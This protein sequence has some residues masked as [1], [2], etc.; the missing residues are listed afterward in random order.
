MFKINDNDDDDDEFWKEFP[1]ES[2]EVEPVS[3]AEKRRRSPVPVDCEQNKKLRTFT[4]DDEPM[5]DVIIPTSPEPS[6]SVSGSNKYPT[7]GA[8]PAN[9]SQSLQQANCSILGN[10]SKEKTPKCSTAKLQTDVTTEVNCKR[11]KRIF[12]GPAGILPK[13]VSSDQLEDVVLKLDTAAVNEKELQPVAVLTPSQTH[14]AFNESPWKKLMSDLGEEASDILKKFSIKE[15]HRRAGKKLL[16]QGKV[17]LLFS[18]LDAI[19]FS[20]LDASVHLRDKTGTIQG[21]VH[22]NLVK[23][24]RDYLQPGTVMVLKNVGVISPTPRTHYLNITTNNLVSICSVLTSGEV[25]IHWQENNTS[26]SK[27]VAN[28]R[29]VQNTKAPQTSGSPLP[30]GSVINSPKLPSSL[31]PLNGSPSHL[32]FSFPP[33][34]SRV[35]T[36]NAL[37]TS[38]PINPQST[39]CDTSS[40]PPHRVINFQ[41][42]ASSTPNAGK[43]GSNLTLAGATPVTATSS[44]SSSSDKKEL[45]SQSSN[46]RWRFKSTKTL[47][48]VPPEPVLK[49]PSGNTRN[50]PLL[51]SAL[52]QLRNS[53]FG[54]LPGPVSCDKNSDSTT[55][56]VDKYR[57]HP[58]PCQNGDSMDNKET[59][60]QDDLWQDDLSDDILSQISEDIF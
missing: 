43:V 5:P 34:H 3:K 56:S 20:N 1:L 36:P 6:T 11:T 14:E 16:C 22:R 59:L 7:K 58:T 55:A 41:R 15:I 49:N 2:F 51:D 29:L 23:E 27:L 32:P 38:T 39:I 53:S 40:T 9:S 52:S 33:S 54:K 18:I 60:F 50:N 45:L 13:L 21:T 48:K 47:P 24:Y 12:P 46:S 37:V 35:S 44:Q 10:Y 8:T 31:N 57:L 25:D 4:G 26:Y 28:A 30:K 17:L 42:I 19:D